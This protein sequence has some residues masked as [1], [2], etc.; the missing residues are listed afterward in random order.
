MAEL[1]IS[2]NSLG[3]QYRLG[4]VE[5]GFKRLR[6]VVRRN[7]G[8]GSIWALKDTTFDVR[9]GETVAL[10]GRNGAGKSTLLKI[11]ARITE[12][13][14]GYADVR[15]RVGALL[16]IGTGFHGD[17][18]GRENIFLNGSIL[19]MTRAEVR[20]NLDAIIEFSGVTKHIDTPVKWYSSGMYVRLAFAIAAHLE[21]E[22]LIVDEVLAVGDAEFQRRCIGRM[23]EVA[24]DGRTV[25]FVSHNAQAVRSLCERAI[26]LESG[27]IVDDADTNSVLRRYLVSS[28][29][30][31]SS[32][33]R[34]WSPAEMP[35]TD[36]CRLMGVRV[37]NASDQPTSSI[38]SSESV[39]VVFDVDI[40][41]P[42]AGLLVAFDLATADGSGVFRSYSADSNPDPI[43]GSMRGLRTLRC[44]IPPGLLNAGRY[45]ISVR[46]YARGVDEI[47]NETSV[48]YFDV[49]TD[50]G[51]S[52]HIGW[53]YARPGVIAP[54]LRWEA[55]EARNVLDL[56][57]GAS[58]RV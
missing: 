56:P 8:A 1:A 44:P 37:V 42:D 22:I 2:V 17:L 10:V 57:A 32:G 11:L 6:R 53:Q 31:E 19:G 39:S 14:A 27:Q 13:T 33:R 52:I 55:E 38:L 41:V 16:E 15:G 20:R 26:L 21:P 25:I 49:T 48:L 5:T 28:T 3:K 47:I 54:V 7:A 50:H 40:R 30:L 24:H 34:D 23:S 12:P 46:A 9:Q 29:G 4:S 43:P 36:D 58:I 18:T 51:E 45:V 35:G